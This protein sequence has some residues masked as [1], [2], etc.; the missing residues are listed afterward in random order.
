MKTQCFFV[1]PHCS[2]SPLCERAARPAVHPSNDTRKNLR[3][4]WTNP[5]AC[6]NPERKVSF[7]R[8]VT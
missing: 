6:E 1:S 3:P 7:E 5:P 4:H 8:A 2:L